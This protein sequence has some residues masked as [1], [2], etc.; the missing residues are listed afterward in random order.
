MLFLFR[1]LS[2]LNNS[3]LKLLGGVEQD[4][5]CSGG[6]GATVA[7][8]VVLDT[9]EWVEEPKLGKENRRLVT[10]RGLIK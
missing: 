3:V 1:L 6:E 8:E 2:F 5:V 10:K 4:G 7:W 9:A